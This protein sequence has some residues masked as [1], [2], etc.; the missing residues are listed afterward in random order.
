M[1]DWRANRLVDALAKTAAAHDAA[2]SKVVRCLQKADVAAAHAACLLGIVAHAANNHTTSELGDG[3][4]VVQTDSRDSSER[5]WARPVP[6]EVP[7]R[8]SCA[9][10]SS[11]KAA[12]LGAKEVAPWTAPTPR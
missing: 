1:L 6:T 7:S 11:C 10:T 9:S 8:S 3:G 5:Q 12:P 4:Q 2:P